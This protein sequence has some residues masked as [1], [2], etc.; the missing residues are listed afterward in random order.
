MSILELQQSEL[1]ENNIADAKD[2]EVL[3]RAMSATSL[4]NAQKQ[5]GEDA[6]VAFELHTEAFPRLRNA[7]TLEQ[8][9][10]QT[11]R[12]PTGQLQ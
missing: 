5:A 9:V 11:G 4:K 6:A 2:I 8:F 1:Q 7:M 3:S 10:K 12:R